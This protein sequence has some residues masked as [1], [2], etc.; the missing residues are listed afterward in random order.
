MT[1]LPITRMTLYKHGIGFFERRAKLSGERVDLSFRVEEMN[2]VL[3]SLTAID[4]GGGHVRVV[5]S[6]WLTTAVYEIC[7]SACGDGVSI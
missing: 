5:L 4:W 2:D 6:T 7:W 3:K 1:N